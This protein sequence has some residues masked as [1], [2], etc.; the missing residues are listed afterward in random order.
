MFLSASAAANISQ[1]KAPGL[2]IRKRLGAGQIMKELASVAEGRGGGRPDRAQA[3]SKKPEKA[4]EVCEKAVEIIQRA[5][6]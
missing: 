1:P 2:G 5:F 6:Q 4:P 3:G